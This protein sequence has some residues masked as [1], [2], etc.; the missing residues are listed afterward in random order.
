MDGGFP[1]SSFHVIFPPFPPGGEGGDEQTSIDALQ[2][3]WG[4]RPA[5]RGNKPL[6]KEFLAGAKHAIGTGMQC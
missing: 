1:P 6:R 4:E 2:T 5:G 3:L